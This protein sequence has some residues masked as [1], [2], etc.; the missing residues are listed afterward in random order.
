MTML[1]SKTFPHHDQSLRSTRSRRA[2]RRQRLGTVAAALIAVG[3]VSSSSSWAGT[4]VPLPAADLGQTNI[5]DGEAGPGTMF[6]L[7]GYGAAANSLKEASGNTVNGSNHQDIYSL[8]LH[9]VFVSSTQ[10]V[11]AYP[12]VEVLLP[13]AHIQNIFSVPGTGSD[14]NI[15]DITIA[16]FF[17][18][19]PQ[20]PGKGSVSVRAA[21]QVTAPT[22][23]YHA[24]NAVNTGYGSWQVSPYLAATWRATAKWELS[25][26]FIDDWSS[27][28]DGLSTDDVPARLRAGNFMVLNASMSYAVTQASR[29]GV[30]GYM[31]RQVSLSTSDGVA[32]PGSLQRVNAL[33]PVTRWVIG[34]SNLL[35]AAYKEFGAANRPEGYT[36]NL[37]FQMFF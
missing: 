36:A 14:T 4:P 1:T 11:G 2:E 32:V 29:I 21:I 34:Q 31:L 28:V 13:F 3:M 8:I 27:H 20:N 15:G 12:G 24:S 35:F 18:W 19:S 10:I 16:P 26:R 37:R 5:L 25:G 22:G 17:E 23:D 9:P 30:G 33:G 7:I 6:E